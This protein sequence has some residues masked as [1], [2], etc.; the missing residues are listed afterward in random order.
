MLTVRELVERYQPDVNVRPGGSVYS[1]TTE[2]MSIGPGDVIAVEGRHYLVHRDAVE[3]G[4]AYK[5]T[6]FWVKKAMELETGE[7]KLLKLVFHESFHLKWGVV[8]V[9]CYR[10]PRKEARMLDLVRGDSRFMQGR[11]VHDDAGNRIRVIDIIQGKRIDYVVANIKADH[12]TYFHEFYPQIL[13]RFIKACGAIAHLHDHDELHGDISLDHLMREYSTGAYRW[14]DFDYAYE[15]QANPFALD[16]FGLGR[17]LLCITGKWLYSPQ[18]LGDLGVNF[19]P[20]NL[21]PAD[22][23][24]VHRSEIMNLKKLFPYI[25]DRLNNVLLHFSYGAEVCYDSVPEFLDDL[26]AAAEM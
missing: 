21:V 16:L 13:D 6:K 9:K 20:V 12:E 26:R 24:C 25:P 3:R 1:D 10:S 15:A 7:A 11:T 23:S 19:N 22:Y 2:F 4:L 14:I 5:D 17:I 8:K 18:T